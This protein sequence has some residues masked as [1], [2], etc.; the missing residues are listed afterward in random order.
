MENKNKSQKN[1][2]GFYTALGISFTMVLCACIYSYSQGTENDELNSMEVAE[3]TNSYE[4]ETFQEIAPEIIQTETFAEV[5]EEIIE[6]AAVVENHYIPEETELIEEKTELSEISEHK[7][8][9]PLEE[10]KEII[11]EFSNGELVKSESENCWK[12]HNGTDFS[13][14]KGDKIFAT[15]T[16]VILS[17]QEEGLWGITVTIDHENG[18]VTRYTGLGNDI[19][20]QVDDKVES[21]QQI[22]TLGEPSESESLLETHFHFEVLKNNEYINPLEYLSN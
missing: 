2:K 17:V 14:S 7:I 22:G 16:G 13:A 12:T 6:Q 10:E 19:S 18:Y 20:V 21:G 3:N 4:Y 5:T 1:K 8:S 9:F 11:Q 15:D